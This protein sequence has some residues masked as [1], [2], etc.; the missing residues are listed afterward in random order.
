MN[1]EENAGYDDWKNL[2]LM[3]RKI[4]VRMDSSVEGFII[5]EILK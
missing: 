2:G 5:T 1:Q 4:R 3:I